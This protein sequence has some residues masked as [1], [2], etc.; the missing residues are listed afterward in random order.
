MIEMSNRI[1]RQYSDHIDHFI[2]VQFLD[3]IGHGRIEAGSY[4]E[5]L[6]DRVFR[7]L[8]EGIQAGGRRYEFLAFGNTQLREHGA[9]FFAACAGQS[10]CGVPGCTG[11]SARK[12]RETIGDVSGINIVAKQA[13]R[14]GQVFSTTRAL[15]NRQNDVSLVSIADF[16]GGL[17]RLFCFTDGIGMI[18][19]DLLQEVTHAMGCSGRPPCAIQF[20]LGGAKGVLALVQ[21]GNVTLSNGSKQEVGSRQIF[22]RPS[23]IKFQSDHD[24]LEIGL[25][26]GFCHLS[27]LT[28]CCSASRK[29]WISV[30]ESTVHHHT[31]VARCR[32][33]D[34]C[35]YAEESYRRTRCQCCGESISYS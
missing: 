9:F 22:L 25:Q 31:V 12:I 10:E 13:S 32:N 17:D 18:T 15:Q 24:N 16:E 20:R 7:T 3:E 4:S 23:Q 26:I 2:R 34:F 6:L 29:I 14:V 35:L 5:N 27:A 19:S 28:E 33:G 11:F 30:S 8:A 21:P 1:L